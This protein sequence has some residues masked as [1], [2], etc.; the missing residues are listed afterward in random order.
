M[1]KKKSIATDRYGKIF[2]YLLLAAYTA[3]MFVLFY[4]Q[5]IEYGGNY[6]SD[7]GPYIL[8]IQGLEDRFSYPYPLMFALAW[9]LARI[10][11]PECAMAIAVTLL[12]TLSVWMT[13]RYLL[14]FTGARLVAAGEEMT[15]WREG[16]THVLVLSLFFV[17]MLYLPYSVS[18]AGGISR[19]MGTYTPNPLWNATYLATRPFSVVS[20]FA[21][22]D[23][24]EKYERGASP[25]EYLIFA[26]SLFLGAL[27]KPSFTL[28]AAAVYAVVLLYR[29][30]KSRGRNLVKSLYFGFCVLPAGFLMLY[31]FFGV[32]SGTNSAGEES[33]IGIAPGAVWTLF[34]DNILRSV[35]L[36]CAFPLLVLLLNI[37][38][39]KTVSWFRHAW[40]LW[41]SGFL[42]FFFL[43]EKGF[44]MS[45]GNFAWGYMHGMFFVFLAGLMMLVKNTLEARL[46]KEKC[47]VCLEWLFY[48]AHLVCG[49]HFFLYMLAGQD[50]L[51]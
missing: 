9:V 35:L 12:N 20:F 42:M 2:Q 18:T 32:F 27:A 33:G 31:Q 26:V 4:R 7:M 47:A 22:A 46:K 50:P 1:A 23:L 43:Y 28:I 29:F 24:L 11:T 5:C 45:H 49:V 41:L 8:T 40:Q 39:L 6:W 25:R 19:C 38:K 48:A 37:K 3:V 17:S 44:R 14:R 30:F 10:C 13:D 15:P 36:G 16:M 34:T 51:V 21:G